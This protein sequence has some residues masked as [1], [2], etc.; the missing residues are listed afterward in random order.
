MPAILK[1]LPSAI[2]IVS[3]MLATNA[4][5]TPMISEF[6]AS[7][8]DTLQLGD[9]SSPDWIEIHNPG[10]TSVDLDGWHLTGGDDLA[11]RWTFPAGVTLAPG[12]YLL[13]YATGKDLS[14]P[15]A[16][17]HTNFKLS[18]QGEYL[19]LTQPSGEVAQEFSPTYPE[20]YSDV[21]YGFRQG[22]GEAVY[23]TT[24]TPGEPNGEPVLGFVKDTKFS[25]KRGFFDA[26]FQL[27]VTSGTPG[28]SLYYTMDGS[29]PDLASAHVDAVDPD[30]P[31]V[32]TLAINST[33]VVR[34]FAARTDFVSTNIDTQ[35][36]LF[37]DQ[38]IAHSVMAPSITGHSVWGPQMRDALLEIPSISLITQ[39][40]IPDDEP[41]VANPREIPVS[42]E[43]IFP[44][45]REGFQANAG[46]ERFGGI[47]S[48]F[49]KKAL[50][51]SF[52]KIYG[53]KRLKFDLFSDTP[54]GGDTAVNSFNQIILRNGSHDALFHTGYPSPRDGAYVRNRYYF[55]RQLEMGH[56]SLRGKFV[57]VYLNGV[58]YG[59]YHLMERPTADHMA[60]YEGGEE[61]DYDV[62]KGRSG[63]S[64]VEGN[65]S[66]WDTLLNNDSNMESAEDYLDVDNYIDY[67]LLNFYGGND[68]DWYPN[69]NWV[70][71]RKRETGGQYQFFM[72]DNDFLNRR[73]PIVNAT[74][75]GGP[76]N[77][78]RDLKTDPEFQMRMADRARKYFFNGGILTKERVEADFNELGERISRT[79]IPE[80]ARWGT[81]PSRT[82][83]PATF[84]AA[85]DWL[86]TGFA[87]NRT[88]TV[89]QQMRGAGVYPD[90]RAPFFS[91][92]GGEVPT[93]YSLRI[94][95]E[96]G[97]LYYTLDGSDPRLS[98]G[99][100][101]PA[102]VSV[103]GP[104]TTTIAIPAGSDWTFDNSGTDHGSAWYASNFDDSG[105][106][107]GPAPLGF[108]R[109][110][111]TIIAT[112]VFA[113]LPRQVTFYCRRSFEIDN[114]ATVARASLGLHADG[115]AIVY[116]NGTEI[117]RDNMPEGTI[118]PTTL[119]TFDGNEGVF[120]TFEFDP[121]LLLDGTNLITVEVHNISAGSSDM[122]FD[123]ELKVDRVKPAAVFSIAE[124]TEVR[125]RV[126][127]NGEWSALNEATFYTDQAATSENLVISEIN[128]H[129]GD[130]QGGD[131]EFVE[132]MNV[133]NGTINLA[134]VAFTEGISYQFGDFD[135]LAP[136][137][138]IV[139]VSDEAAFKAAYGND[140]AIGGV[141]TSRLANDGE[142]L[143][144]GG[145][146]GTIIQ[147]L[148]YNDKEPW[149]TSPD[150][151]GN[152]L[153][154]VAPAAARD[155]DLPQNWRPSRMPGGT[156]GSS[157]S[158]PYTGNSD[159]EIL[160]Y[161]TG[162]T[163]GGVVETTGGT[164]I[165]EHF[166]ID[167][168]DDAAITV[169][170][171]ADMVTWTEEGVNFLNQSVPEN[172]ATRMRWNL[173]V[174]A[175][176]PTFARIVVS[177]HQ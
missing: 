85:I 29:D 124:T 3:F 168:A 130:G 55:D 32:L 152:S 36:Y 61:E 156:P 35:T 107:A 31:P 126:L 38:V 164:S 118:T 177:I 28:A 172:G 89:I 110:N 174:E 119:A 145:P 10:T 81:I 5:A 25:V 21:S 49:P 173:P 127:D 144:L 134:G 82:Y 52:K 171:S 109:I 147:T 135:S 42:I 103:G 24:P 33:T 105:W 98:G 46:V 30:S 58:Y 59:H 78:F 142:R 149:P 83:T 51:V 114:A 70:A 117:L 151:T 157:D 68:H 97:D 112:Q 94:S 54:Y 148:R 17:M 176:I 155:P 131:A 14:D 101:N 73:L 40:E 136:G 146:G 137:Q 141:Y 162:G 108:G 34:A 169:Q 84:N 133:S 2:L 57:H 6:M 27:E 69:H 74:D 123:L 154:L 13:V 160:T 80:T 159:E 23:F 143:T 20:Q 125:A 115:G 19:A 37:P 113:G 122:V 75:N 116:L 1:N 71:A 87:E 120:D 170:V 53:P 12:A 106:A 44:D 90:T 60:T 167:G 47:Y 100:I 91:Q 77:I 95:H 63:I 76:N 93:N 166:R 8:D 161:A 16:A 18:D 165:F 9:G 15:S 86:A 132:L 158:I 175:E 92:H 72:W 96:V 150:G 138:R 64:A 56:P 139:L 67:M 99:M 102:A 140:L 121:G 45:G 4:V 153:V 22:P 41:S 7:N 39:E 11:T 128:Y 48:L 111:D 66:A 104:F 79:I 50:R 129:P 88:E 62:M 65:R 26:P 43:M 163:T